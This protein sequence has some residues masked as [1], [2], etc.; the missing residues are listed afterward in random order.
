M[1]TQNEV[2]IYKSYYPFVIEGEEINFICDEGEYGPFT[3]I[4]YENQYNYVGH[5][6]PT[7]KNAIDF[8]QKKN[9]ITL[10]DNEIQIAINYN[11]TPLNKRQDKMTKTKTP[12][13]TKTVTTSATKS[14][15]TAKKTTSSKAVSPK[16][17]TSTATSKKT[18]T[19]KKTTTTS[20]PKAKDVKA[21]TSAKKVAKSTTA[22]TSTKKTSKKTSTKKSDVSKKAAEDKPAKDAEPAATEKPVKKFSVNRV[23]STTESKKKTA[24][25]VGSRTV[26]K[27]GVVMVDPDKEIEG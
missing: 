3:I 1:T 13:P 25:A 11:N 21:K 16:K 10:T 20:K 7:L 19:A 9:Q 2:I 5:I 27:D 18:T 23:D 24:K 8:W 12:S 4:E 6:N 17:T 14:S 26:V 15:K 22:K